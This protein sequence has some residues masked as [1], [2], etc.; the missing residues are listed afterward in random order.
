MDDTKCILN[1]MLYY[2]FLSNSKIKLCH[3]EENIIS[4]NLSLM[5]IPYVTLTMNPL[6]K[7]KTV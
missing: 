2:L 4:I 1:C 3:A 6:F 7:N 5:I